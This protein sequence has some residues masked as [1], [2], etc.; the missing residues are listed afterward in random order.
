MIK[1]IQVSFPLLAEI[2]FNAP[3]A[4]GIPLGTLLLVWFIWAKMNEQGGLGGS[5]T[6]EDTMNV[7]LNN[8]LG[9]DTVQFQHSEAKLGNG[10][11]VIKYTVKLKESGTFVIAGGKAQSGYFSSAYCGTRTVSGDVGDVISGAVSCSEF[12]SGIW[13]IGAFRSASNVPKS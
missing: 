11:C 1:T 8:E 6:S 2:D 12:H 3:T 9:V 7:A 10:R 5:Y 4:I 13:G